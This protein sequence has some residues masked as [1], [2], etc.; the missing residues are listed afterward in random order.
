LKYLEH[1]FLRARKRKEIVAFLHSL[2]DLFGSIN[3]EST[4]EDLKKLIKSVGRSRMMRRIELYAKTH[5][6]SSITKVRFALERLLD[7]IYSCDPAFKVK[8]RFHREF[9]EL[10]YGLNSFLSYYRF[11]RPAPPPPRPPTKRKKAA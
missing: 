10:E 2:S 6:I 5:R 1:P 9:E 7:S 8:E 4:A 11:E 3:F